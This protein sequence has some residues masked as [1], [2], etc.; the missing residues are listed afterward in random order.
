MA[1]K[2]FSLRLNDEE[3]D[4]IRQSALSYGLPEGTFIKNVVLGQIQRDRLSEVIEE[5]MR[6]KEVE[7]ELWQ[8][9]IKSIL[10]M[11]V[12]ITKIASEMKI[13]LSGLEEKSAQAA[14]ALFSDK[15]GS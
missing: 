15:F 4:S 11:K 5:E 7:R 9:E 12:A 2:I 10:F 14:A 1:G 8:Q 3:R 13:D 6:V